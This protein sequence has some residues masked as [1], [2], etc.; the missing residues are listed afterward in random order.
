MIHDTN[1]KIVIH[2]LKGVEI[3]AQTNSLPSISVIPI[4]IPTPQQKG[5]VPGGGG[6]EFSE[7]SVDF[8]VDEDFNNY[9]SIVEWM[10]KANIANVPGAQYQVKRED[11]YN[12]CSDIT[13]YLLNNNMEEYAAIDF[14]NA[15]P[16]NLGE[17]SFNTNSAEPQPLKSNVTFRYD[18]FKR[19]NS[20]LFS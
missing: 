13:L 6:L 8:I 11:I 20:P 16:V 7:L 18:Y 1:S 12:P 2:K 15:M 4:E 5:Y 14:V 3:F 19:N 10:Y 17:L 9:F